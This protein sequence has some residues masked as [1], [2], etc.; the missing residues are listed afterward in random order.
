MPKGV[1]PSYPLIQGGSKLESGVEEA[2][3]RR[4]DE[5]N[6]NCLYNSIVLYCLLLLCIYPSTGT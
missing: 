6:T 1:L 3:E 4:E 5:W 2:E